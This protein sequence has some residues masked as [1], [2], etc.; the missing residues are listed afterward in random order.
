MYR[1][2]SSSLIYLFASL[3]FLVQVGLAYNIE[4]GLSL[5][6]SHSVMQTRH[7]LPIANWQK[8]G[9]VV[10]A[11]GLDQQF[12]TSRRTASEF[13]LADFTG[14]YTHRSSSFFLTLEGSAFT[15]LS[16]RK[17]FPPSPGDEPFATS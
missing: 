11:T 13:I 2:P 10:A 16:R 17:I 8:Q 14:A 1:R 12:S 7:R 5:L 9:E 3:I 6:P 15:Y 4:A